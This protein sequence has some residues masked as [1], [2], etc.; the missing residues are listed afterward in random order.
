MIL[1]SQQT[2][3]TEIGIDHPFLEKRIRLVSR[4]SARVQMFA[5]VTGGCHSLGIGYKKPGA[6]FIDDKTAA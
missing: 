6:A 2:I 1:S 3:K 4:Q 5:C